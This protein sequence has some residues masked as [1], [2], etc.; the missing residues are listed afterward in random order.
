MSH[1]MITMKYGY[2]MC[3]LILHVIGDVEHAAEAFVPNRNIVFIV[4]DDLRPALKTYGD[5]KAVTP[6]ID[7]LASKSFVF[8]NAYAQVNK[9]I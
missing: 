4:V 3:A 5:N 7:R 6:N 2:I 9:N 8:R 1:A